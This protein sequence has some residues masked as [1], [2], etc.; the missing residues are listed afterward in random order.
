M[1]SGGEFKISLEGMA[2]SG[3]DLGPSGDTADTKVSSDRW[4]GMYQMQLDLLYAS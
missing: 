3:A 4:L 2:E 1:K